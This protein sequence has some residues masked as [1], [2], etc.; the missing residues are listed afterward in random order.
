MAQ[1]KQD[2]SF[3]T[4]YVVLRVSEHVVS[5]AAMFSQLSRA[6]STI[7]LRDDSVKEI[8]GTE[9]VNL[10][11]FLPNGQTQSVTFTRVEY[12]FTIRNNLLLVLGLLNKSCNVVF[13]DGRCK[14][15]H[16]NTLLTIG[17]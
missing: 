14:V 6:K 15:F 10:T 11:F 4:W 17:Q 13:K 2:T 7:H 1:G 9:H 3:T 16:E 12:V 5:T 8:V